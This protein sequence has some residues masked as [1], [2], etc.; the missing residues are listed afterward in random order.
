VRVD[1]R[2]GYPGLREPARVVSGTSFGSEAGERP[3]TLAQNSSR[4]AGDGHALARTT[5][6]PK[7]TAD[8]RVAQPA[9]S[10]VPP[11]ARSARCSPPP[12][13]PP[14]K[15][16]ADFSHI[17]RVRASSVLPHTIDHLRGVCRSLLRLIPDRAG[18]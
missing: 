1:L 5:G 10:A 9:P 15:L 4:W 13:P 16:R 14:S 18:G 17:L 11:A 12:A 8:Q 7:L 3:V 6:P 2:A